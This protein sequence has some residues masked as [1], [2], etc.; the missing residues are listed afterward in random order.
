MIYVS[1]VLGVLALLA[2]PVVAFLR[3]SMGI[4]FLGGQATTII[5]LLLMSSFQLFFLFI[6]GQYVARTYDEARNRPLYIV[7]STVGFEDREALP[8]RQ[9]E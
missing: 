2:I 1:L 9:L 6:L 4:A 7:A 8:E 5:L 3:L